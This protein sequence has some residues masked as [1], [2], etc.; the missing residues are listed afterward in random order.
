MPDNKLR[1][2]NHNEVLF[3]VN[4]IT[5]VADY[6]TTTNNRLDVNAT[7]TTSG[8]AIN[9]GVDSNIKA[10]VLDLASANPLTVAITDGSGNQITS[11]G[12][13]TQYAN[14]AVSATPTG[15]VALGWDGANVRALSTN[16][17]GVLALPTGASTSALQTTGNTSLATIATNTTNAGTPTLQSG[18]TTAVTQATAANL[19]ATVVGTGTFATQA[20]QSGTWNITNVSG[21]VSLPTGAATSAKQPALGTAGTASADVITVQGIASMTALKVDG[22]A[23]TQ[24]V[25][26]T[27]TVTGVATATN[28]TGG[29]QK[30]QVVD[31]SG[32]V[33]GSTSNALDVNIKSGGFNGVVTNAGT[34]ATQSTLSAGTNY[35]GKVRIT[36]G[37]NDVSL[38]NLTNSKPV[39]TAI[40]DGSGNQITSFGGGT[41]YATGTT[42]ATPTG[43]LALG[44]D[45][46]VLRAL[47]T[48]TSGNLYGR[49]AVITSNASGS[50]LNADIVPSTDLAGYQSIV[51]QLTTSAT[52]ATLTFQ[53]S[54][55]NSTWVSFAMRQLAGGN[56]R[57]MAFETSNAGAT[58]TGTATWY[59]PVLFRYFRARLTAYSS[60]TATGYF[61]AT[62]N[63]IPSPWAAGVGQLDT[64][65]IS[66]TVVGTPIA[67]ADPSSATSGFKAVGNMNNAV[68]NSLS[69]A[70]MMAVGLGGV[71][72]AD[73]KFIAAPMK[74]A[75]N[76]PLGASDKS[77]PLG[78]GLYA[79]FDDTSTTAVSEDQAALL[80][81]SSRRALYTEGQWGNG[82]TNTANPVVT[83]G[84]GSNSIVAAPRHSD[85]FGSVRATAFGNTAVYTPTS[86][87]KFR[88]LGYAYSATPDVA[89][90][91]GARIDV[92][93]QDSTTQV[94]AT[95]F[96]FYAPAI[97]G[98]AFGAND[99][100][101]F[102]SLGDGFLSASANNV[103][104][105]NLSAALT[106][107]NVTVNAVLT[108]E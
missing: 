18:S 47:N 39:P 3:G 1:T 8:G 108:E 27:V 12:G 26:G 36:D 44:Y 4:S 72:A 57:G 35:I 92:E 40:V 24:P 33:I 62:A 61:M 64:P 102:I 51:L 103:L 80:R 70:N 90:S 74:H 66:N 107:G 78:A 19:N 17:S 32:N 9:D 100:S 98:T 34:F 49:G 13:G 28:Q 52:S 77:K 65:A 83:A 101:G 60:G 45:G 95:L 10:T 5:N 11:F 69:A 71:D 86:G 84:L 85:K 76:L 87:K 20:A 7:V 14:G 37:T 46:T 96:S 43:T 50:S 38:L 91:G 82:V 21:T 6:V 94:K 15:T 67:L 81:M 79:E 53:G 104:N 97:A 2:P 48:D 30:T 58:G 105:V 68:S 23:V 25:S 88:L 42:Q 99:Q 56:N 55:D 63:A 41:Q 93:L 89:T 29:G 73:S 59:S 16:S 75:A 106:S 22:S 54:H 31:G